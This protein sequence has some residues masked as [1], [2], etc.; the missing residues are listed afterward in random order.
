V[1]D[2]PLPDSIPERDSCE[3]CGSGAVFAT[4]E[5]LLCAKHAL[6]LIDGKDDWIPLLRTP[7][8]RTDRP[9]G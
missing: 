4:P 7:D 9:E 2:G 6:E 8:G 3:K 1:N 5:G